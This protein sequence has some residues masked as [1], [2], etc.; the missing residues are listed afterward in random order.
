MKLLLDA[1]LFLA[2]I[3]GWGLLVVIWGSILWGPRP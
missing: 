3:I 2:N 1:A